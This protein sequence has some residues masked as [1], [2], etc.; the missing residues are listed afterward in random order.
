MEPE[1]SGVAQNKKVAKK[2]LYAIGGGVVVASL[3]I[4]VAFFGDY[5]GASV[6]R[7][8]S[9][10]SNVLQ[11]EKISLAVSAQQ[12]SVAKKVE[13][14]STVV[15]KKTCQA[16]DYVLNGKFVEFSIPADYRLGK[17]DIQLIGFDKNGKRIVIGSKSVL[18]N[19][20]VAVSGGSSNGGSGGGSS[21]GEG[22]SSL[23]E[24]NNPPLPY[25]GDTGTA[26]IILACPQ[27]YLDVNGDGKLTAEDSDAVT[28]YI[29]NKAQTV[30][31]T[32]AAWQNQT[33]PFD[34]NNDQAVTPL[35][36]LVVVNAV[37][38]NTGTIATADCVPL[39][40][41]AR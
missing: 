41:A 23:S 30:A 7:F 35:D 24:N 8:N 17:A 20:A 33:Q 15:L 10:R 26:K 3:L 34:V 11:G 29:N 14:C 39:P 4:F 9:P 1:N 18:V 25:G 12:A 38:K 40:Y 31:K 21:S 6:V 27:P 2:F 22:E 19:K 37:D 16:V 32:G 13:I 5:L 36:V 28:A